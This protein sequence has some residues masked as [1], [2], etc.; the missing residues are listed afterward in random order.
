MPPRIF[1]LIEK[2]EV[3]RGLEFDTPM[4]AAVH[5]ERYNLHNAVATREINIDEEVEMF[6][7]QMKGID[8][9]SL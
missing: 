8:E 3:L 9:T 5:K 7:E 2:L 1:L 4:A 6:R